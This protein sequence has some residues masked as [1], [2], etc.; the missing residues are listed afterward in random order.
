VHDLQRDRPVEPGVG[1]Q[2]DGRH[3]AMGEMGL[4]PVPAIK[5]LTDRDTGEGRIHCERF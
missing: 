2:V 1:A 4:H 5:K 3:A